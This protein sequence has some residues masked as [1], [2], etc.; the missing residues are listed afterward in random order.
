MR[1]VSG[2]EISDIQGGPKDVPD[3]LRKLRKTSPKSRVH[4]IVQQG[5]KEGAFWVPREASNDREQG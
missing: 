5:R 1:G 2:S 3:C 4:S